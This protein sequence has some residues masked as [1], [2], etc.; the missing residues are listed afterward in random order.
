MELLLRKS[1]FHIMIKRDSP[2]ISKLS[3]H[4]TAVA[5]LSPCRLVMALHQLLARLIC[6]KDPT[7]FFVAPPAETLM[8]SSPSLSPLRIATSIV[9]CSLNS[10][11]LLS[12]QHGP[13]SGGLLAVCKCLNFI[14]F[15]TSYTCILLSTP[16]VVKNRVAESLSRQCFWERRQI[17]FNWRA[18]TLS[19]SLWALL[20]RALT[21][22]SLPPP[23]TI[24]VHLWALSK[25]HNITSLLACCMSNKT[26]GQQCSV[27]HW[28]VIKVGKMLPS[29]RKVVPCK[30]PFTGPKKDYGIQT[31][32]QLESLAHAA[33]LP[34][35]PTVTDS[36]WKSSFLLH[37]SWCQQFA[38]SISQSS[39]LKILL[40]FI[41]SCM[42]TQADK[43]T[44]HT[45][46]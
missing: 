31:T 10:R 44:I 17:M 4:T 22:T 8:Q 36:W 20:M 37:P 40:F 25:Y 21:P 23:T 14:P 11:N 26:E 29:T 32:T 35:R 16:M 38:I 12:R 41:P 45:F 5:R 1:N 46:E 33:L 43:R 3:G 24:K 28:H 42:N 19:K 7:I 13:D 2:I 9:W 27:F 18:S 34:V 39:S 6:S 15:I 30:F